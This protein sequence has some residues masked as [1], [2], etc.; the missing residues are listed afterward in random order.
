MN[1]NRKKITLRDHYIVNG[2]SRDTLFDACKYAYDNRTRILVTFGFGAQ[3]EMRG[4][5]ISGIEHE[6]GSGESLNIRGY[7][8][9]EGDYYC[10]RAYYNARTRRGIMS[11][12][13]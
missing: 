6:D 1:T 12:F 9:V 4:I 3:M 7:C 13:D 10:F 8:E 2:P 5:L 11:F